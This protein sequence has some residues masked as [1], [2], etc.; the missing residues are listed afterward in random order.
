MRQ[1]VKDSLN[2]NSATVFISPYVDLTIDDF[3][4]Q[5]ESSFGIRNAAAHNWSLSRKG[6]SSEVSLAFFSYGAHYHNLQS[7]GYAYSDYA[8]EYFDDIDFEYR[9]KLPGRTGVALGSSLSLLRLGELDLQVVRWRVT[10]DR[11][12]CGAAKLDL[13]KRNKHSR[14]KRWRIGF[15]WENLDLRNGDDS[16]QL[17]SLTSGWEFGKRWSATLYQKLEERRNLSG[18]THPA[19]LRAEIE[20][21]LRENLIGLFELN[22]Y[23]PDLDRLANSYIYLAAGQRLIGGGRVDLEIL[24]QSRFHFGGNDWSNSQLRLQVELNI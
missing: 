14:L 17:L 21:V 3:N 4:L 7:S 15:L 24:L 8:D 13:E 19:R 20:V 10:Q 23:D 5:G 22:Y 1:N 11:R 6:Q 9:D 2:S 12:E 16:R 18:T